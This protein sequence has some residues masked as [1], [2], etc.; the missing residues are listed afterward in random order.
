VLKGKFL[1]R[2]ISSS[3]VIK[4][5]PPKIV[6]V[7]S[8]TVFPGETITVKGERFQY[9][10]SCNLGRVEFISEK[11]VRV[12][13]EHLSE[14][15][16]NLV[17]SFGTSSSNSFPL[18]VPSVSVVSYQPSIIRRGSVVQLQLSDSPQNYDFRFLKFFIDGFY[19][20]FS[21]T[22]ENQFELKIPLY[23]AITARPDL[24]VYFSDNYSVRVSDAFVSGEKWQCI[25]GTLNLEGKPIFISSQTSNYLLDVTSNLVDVKQFDAN[26]NLW[27]SL[28]TTGILY[29]YTIYAGLEKDGSI[30][31]LAG[32]SDQM[33]VSFFR[34]SLSSKLW[35]QLNNFPV[36]LS[37]YDQPF[38]FVFNEK[39][40][41]G[42]LAGV[43]QYVSGD[44]SWVKKAALPTTH[45]SIKNSLA[46]SFND[47]GYL[48]FYTGNVNSTEYNEFWKYDPIQ[49]KWSDL[50]QAP[51]K[52]Y[53]GGSAV[54]WNNKV[55]IAGK[56]YND[57]G[58]FVV[59]NPGSGEVTSALGPYW[60]SSGKYKIFIIGD[61]L[62]F[63]CLHY[64]QANW[65][66]K[67][68]LSD[69]PYIIE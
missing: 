11:E 50:G 41:V 4:P 10:I 37:F 9:G 62:Y 14:G 24:E 44:D 40:Y 5:L 49:D 1:A 65:I 23:A 39:V 63:V 29:G 46:F 30:Y 6:S 2:N 8:P 12:G 13:L 17:L 19:C 31:V 64:T 60:A 48:G 42:C 7:S 28:N 56:G 52:V 61:Y 47:F 68:K 69:L 35:T 16:N 20:Q 27:T 45:Y 43:F 54:G 38:T 34:F 25:D 3:Q 57:I 51:L 15:K 32:K 33:H 18:T 66:A 36:Q 67:I 22:G 59:Y 58:K 55:L 21:E 53:E 26:S